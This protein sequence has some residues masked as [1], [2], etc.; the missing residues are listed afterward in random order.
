MKHPY[1]ADEFSHTI[2]HLIG[3]PAMRAAVFHIAAACG[4]EIECIGH[5]YLAPAFTSDDT[6]SSLSDIIDMVYSERTVA[7]IFFLTYDSGEV[8]AVRS[9]V[10][11]PIL[12]QSRISPLLLRYPTMPPTPEVPPILPAL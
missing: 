11:S 1:C 5:V 10:T 3:G 12:K 9:Q 6:P 7:V 4:V 8:L 2:S